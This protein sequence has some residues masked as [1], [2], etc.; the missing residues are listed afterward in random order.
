MLAEEARGGRDAQ[1]D[2][3]PTTRVRNQAKRTRSQDP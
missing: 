3:R 1:C 2:S